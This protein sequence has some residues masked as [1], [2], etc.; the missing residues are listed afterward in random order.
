V[1][2]S[3][4][5]AQLLEAARELLERAH[6]PHSRFRVAAALEDESGTVHPG[7]NVESASFSL[8]ICAERNALF[9]ALAR[10]ATRFRRIAIACDEPSACMPCGACRQVLLEYAPDLEVIVASAKG[11]PERIPLRDLLPRPFLEF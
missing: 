1:S 6:A 2:A 5:P 11:A 3:T 8:T 7:V 10:G 9:G 4:D